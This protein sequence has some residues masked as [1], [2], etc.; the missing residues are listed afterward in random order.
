MVE[1]KMFKIGIGKY[2][3][4][5]FWA[6]SLSVAAQQNDK[7]AVYNALLDKYGELTSISLKFQSMN[8]KSITGSLTAKKGNKYVL[9]IGSR[10]ITCNGKSLWNYSTDDSVVIITKFDKSI[11]T[12][13]IE[14][15]FFSLLEEFSPIA[16]KSES[17]SKGTSFTVLTLG[18]NN[19]QSD[20]KQIK[21]WI[22]K[23]GD[24]ASF[25]L[26]KNSSEEKWAVWDILINKKVQDKQFEFSAPKGA[27]IM[28]L[29]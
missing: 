13:S 12:N 6:M 10:T 24:I 9:K 11:H 22:G 3:L 21:L 5:M 19:S 2:I 26:I 27:E 1:V 8:N 15:M 20:I 4:V 23:N 29:R 16:M 14:N 18:S 28:D 7:D 17:S 25:S